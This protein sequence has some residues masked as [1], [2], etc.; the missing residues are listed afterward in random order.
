MKF[1]AIFFSVLFIPFCVHSQLSKFGIGAGMTNYGNPFIKNEYKNNFVSHSSSSIEVFLS[2]SVLLGEKRDLEFNLGYTN[3]QKTGYQQNSDPIDY[4]QNFLY[5]RVFSHRRLKLIEDVLSFDI[6]GGVF[7]NAMLTEEVTTPKMTSEFNDFAG[8]WSFGCI[9]D[10]KFI[11]H[12]QPKKSSIL[13]GFQFGLDLF[14]AMKGTQLFSF[15]N[16]IGYRF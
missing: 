7:Y 3:R 5:L 2:Y 10:Y 14:T 15:N 9:S 11:F 8:N 4:D 6:G 12:S 13:L 1:Q 16:Y